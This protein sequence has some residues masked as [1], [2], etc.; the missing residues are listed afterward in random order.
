LTSSHADAA[1]NKG[2]LLPISTHRTTGISQPLHFNLL[3]H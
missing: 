3:K 1:A 2:L